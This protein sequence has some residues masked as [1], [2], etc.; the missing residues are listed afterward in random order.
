MSL[1]ELAKDWQFWAL[2][3]LFVSYGLSL[4]MFELGFRAGRVEERKHIVR[5]IIA[6]GGAYI[7]MEEEQEAAYWNNERVE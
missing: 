4:L 3:G 7:A 6:H 5:E 2:I 1:G